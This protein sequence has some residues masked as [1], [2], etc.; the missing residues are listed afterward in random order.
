MIFVPHLP[1]KPYSPYIESIF[2][3][4]HFMPDHSIERV[5]P[6]GHLFIL[7]ELDGFE[8]STFDNETLEPN[9]TYQKVWISGVH[10]N[11]IS[12]SAHENSEMFVIQFKPYG[13]YP[14]FH[15][16]I[17]QLNDRV[18]HTEEFFGA[19]LITLRES[20]CKAESSQD[21]FQLA[22]A[23]L[24]ARFDPKAAPPEELVN[25]HQELQEQPTLNGQAITHYPHSQKH[26]IDQFKKYIGLTPKY[27]HRMM[28]FN[29]ILK[30]MQQKEKIAWAQI[31]YECG[32]TDQSY[33]IKEFRHF[34]GFN[35]QE[36]IVEELNKDHPENF[37]PLD[38]NQ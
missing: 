14:F 11:Y 32:F 6:T 21:K 23:W 2:H 16:P 17:E 9:S 34:S 18:V 25:H 38:R 22:E 37:F 15:F 12:I 33:F 35:P 20:L 4:K 5:V 19:E 8:R 3:F 26:L 29:E 10:R 28:R 24:D 31:A 1:E 36:F 7:F 13:A 27:A 30:R